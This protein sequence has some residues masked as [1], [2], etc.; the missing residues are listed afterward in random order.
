[1]GLYRSVQNPPKKQPSYR[2]RQSINADMSWEA[3]EVE[4]LEL[5]DVNQ[6][7]R[8]EDGSFLSRE[9]RCNIGAA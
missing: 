6:N 3:Q 2:Q 4:P 1:M 9:S 7:P 5:P 8:Y